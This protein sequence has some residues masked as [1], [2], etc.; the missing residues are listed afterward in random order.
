MIIHIMTR[1]AIA[2]PLILTELIIIVQMPV[3]RP[4]YQAIFVI[5]ALIVAEANALTFTQALP[6]RP[7]IILP[8]TPVTTTAR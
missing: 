7:P 2:P 3:P 5:T 6:N 8:E 1:S 4:M